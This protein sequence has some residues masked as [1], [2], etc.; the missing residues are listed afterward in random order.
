VRPRR[1][2]TG[3]PESAERL[4]KRLAAAGVGSRR[5]IE[6][7][8]RE[9][10]LQVNGAVPPLGARLKA[11]DQVTLDGRPVRH[12][13]RAASGESRSRVLLLHRSPGE[14]LEI[15]A[16]VTRAATALK[17]SH[18]RGRWLAIQPLP[19]V[20]GGL[21]IL[22]D[23]GALAQQVSRGV[24]RLGI[25]YVL[26]LRGELDEAMVEA[27]REAR[28]SEGAPM[29]ILA[30]EG[31]RGQGTNHWLQVTVRGT[32]AALV[33]HWWNAHGLIVSR[34]MRVR[35]GPIRLGRELPRGRARLL[36]PGERRALLD[37]CAAS[38]AA[39]E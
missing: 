4:Q 13:G 38:E 14:R 22:T 6:R 10:R 18:V 12:E 20:D 2:A 5:E 7:W 24:Q 36:T 11:Q 23:D 17:L 34:L 29:Q 19:A 21:E 27:F 15:E 39:N 25:E 32:R 16:A 33:R 35:F 8:I 31:R 37:E 28:E 30:A 26:R 1:P 3:G 9:G